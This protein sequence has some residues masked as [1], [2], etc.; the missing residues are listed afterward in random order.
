[1][2]RVSRKLDRTARDAEVDFPS[3]DKV[4]ERNGL[5]VRRDVLR[6]AVWPR[7]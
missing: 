2:Q 6:A 4:K 5:A 1:M 3:L 7:R